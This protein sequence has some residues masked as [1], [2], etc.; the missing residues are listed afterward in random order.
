MA[1][2]HVV[3]DHKLH[4]LGRKEDLY[5]VDLSGKVV[6]VL[7]ILFATTTMTAALADG[8]ALVIPTMDEA[9][10]RDEGTRHAPGSHVLCG[11]LYSEVFDGFAPTTPLALLRHGVRDKKLIHATTN[12]TVAVKEAA[13]AEH[14]YVGSLLNGK[15]LAELVLSRHRGSPIVIVCSGSMGN[16][17]L[18]DFYGAGYLVELLAPAF[19]VDADLSDGARA[20]RALYRSGQPFDTLINCRVGRMMDSRGLREEVAYATRLSSLD[21]VP[22]VRDGVIV[23]L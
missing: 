7:D 21:L 14:L 4:V 11:E 9:S 5:T 2:A 6:I 13:G 20:A 18:E 10:A 15:A 17:N 3:L 23:P 16:F 1:H 19:P 12:G 22:V 8:A